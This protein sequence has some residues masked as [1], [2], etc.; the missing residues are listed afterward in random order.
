M[1]DSSDVLIAGAG[2]AGLCLAAALADEGLTVT[3]VDRLPR[4]ALAAPPPDGRDIALTHRAVDILGRLG[5]WQR[6]PEAEISP[7]REAHVVNG[8]A[9]TG[10]AFEVDGTS[11][12]A[13]GYLVPNH[14]IRESAFAVATA[15]PR[16][17]L[18]D[19]QDV[20]DVEIRGDRATV[21]L[22]GGDRIDA[23]LFIAADSRFSQTRRRLGIGAEMRD[24]GR[25]ILVC[26]MRIERPH[27]DIAHE[28]FHYGHTLA[29]LPIRG[30][31]AS[32]VITVSPTR[33]DELM[34]MAPAAFDALITSWFDARFGQ[35]QLTG[36]RHAYPL[37]AVYAHR[38]SGHRCALVGDTAVGM[39]PV[40]AHGFNF[41][42]YGIETLRE[43]IATARRQQRDFGEATVL[44]EYDRRHRR[45]TRP[46]YL[47][48]N[49]LVQ[50]FTDDRG[51]AR[52][53]RGGVLRVADRLPPLKAG[54]TR[55]LT[56]KSSAALRSAVTG[57]AT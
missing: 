54:I 41:G 26:R 3:I 43:V 30:G 37:V 28:C 33:A 56:G 32:I 22:S 38:F 6:Y 49:L 44:Q 57:A 27:D 5:C 45:T 55:L 47:G 23:R 21:S 29:L 10:L 36:E 50:L 15:Q 9:T 51:A 13:L 48:T 40:T 16:V 46:I 31:L 12:P 42:L 20:G 2:P 19:G 1:S 7:I 53:L 39:H 17:R 35:M 11:R 4:R 34:A 14:V 8:R 52:L 24:F 25:T 18:I